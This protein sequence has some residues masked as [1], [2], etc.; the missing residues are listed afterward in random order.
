M[1]V[2]HPSDTPAAGS[3]A[4]LVQAHRPELDTSRI[5]ADDAAPRPIERH[6]GVRGDDFT[7]V[8]RRSA[9]DAM[10]AHGSADTAVEVCGVLVGRLYRDYDGVYLLIHAHIAGDKAASKQTQVTFTAATWDDIQRRME[11]TYPGD[12]VV[13]WYHTHPGFGVFLSGMDLFIQDHFFNLPWQVAWVYD[14]IAGTD[15]VFVWRQGRSELVPFAV[16]EDAA[17]AA[18]PPPPPMPA[19]Q[20]VA[21]TVLLFAAGFLGVW[22]F[23]QWITGHGF[24]VRLPIEW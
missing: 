24:R 5:D 8:I 20:Q 21:M 6:S 17:L 16:E 4:P 9:L 13:G 14:P 12:K 19:A 1:D 22:F 3:T 2:T 23:L 10:H 15:G 11:S 7:V 18:G